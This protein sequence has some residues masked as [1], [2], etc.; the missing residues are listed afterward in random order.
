MS[1]VPTI[2]KIKV[3]RGVTREGRLWYYEMEATVPSP[4]DLEIVKANIEGTL[5]AWLSNV[6]AVAQPRPMSTQVEPLGEK[7]EAPTPKSEKTMEGVKGLF[8]N[9]LLEKLEFKETEEHIVIR[10]RRYLGSDSFAKIASIVRDAGGEY[11]NAGRGSHFRL[12]SA[13]K[14]GERH[15]SHQGAGV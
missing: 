12:P 11:V 6:V 7:G 14:A 10:P 5:T 15:E 4:G 3:G 9:D 13:R 2:T 1:E 8:P